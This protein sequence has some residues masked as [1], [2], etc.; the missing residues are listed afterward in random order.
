MVL[1]REFLLAAGTMSALLGITALIGSGYGL[2]ILRQSIRQ[3]EE[4]FKLMGDNLFQFAVSL[5]KAAGAAA[6]A[7]GSVDEAKRSLAIAARMAEDVASAISNIGSVTDLKVLGIHPFRG[8]GAVLH[9]G[10][11]EFRTMAGQLRDTAGSLGSDADNM[12]EM[13]IDLKQSSDQMAELVANLRGIA[14]G[15]GKTLISGAGRATYLAAAWA[16]LLGLFLL[17]LAGGLLT[18]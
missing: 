9:D 6:N 14:G 18:A 17:V 8:L 12:R 3:I 1:S 11:R 5:N 10:Q 2:L 4:N 7:A 16:V 15:K 13:S